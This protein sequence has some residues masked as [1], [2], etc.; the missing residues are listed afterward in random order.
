[1][2]VK[3]LRRSQE[4]IEIFFWMIQSM[5]NYIKVPKQSNTAHQL[6]QPLEWEKQS[7]TI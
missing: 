3:L 6:R 2:T 4:E 5:Y 7:Q 1:M